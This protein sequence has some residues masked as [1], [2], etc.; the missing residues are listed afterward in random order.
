MPDARVAAKRPP[1]ARRLPQALVTLLEA[2][3]PLELG[4]SL[5]SLLRLPQTPDGDGHP[6]L[7]L[8]GFGASDASMEPL[9][10]F[11][12][13]K[14]YAVETWGLGRNRGFDRRFIELVEQKIRYL[15]HKSARR[16]SVV[17]WS[18]GGVF[19]FY[20]AHAAPE[21]VRTAISLG[22]PLRNDADRGMPFGI[23]M[24]Y[25]AISGTSAANH[26][27]RSRSRRMREP[28]PSPSTCIYSE[29]D[30]F[31]RP[32]QATLDGAPSDHENIR[33][34]G[35]HLGLAINTSVVLI[36]A[37]RLAQPE[38]KW[39]PFDLSALPERLRGDVT[40][41]GPLAVPPPDAAPSRGT[42]RSSR[43]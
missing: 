34:T 3:M 39:R 18:L 16:V 30:A 5:L 13:R 36:I 2:R 4:A 20:A 42:P 24:A 12:A 6:V 27:A 7:L 40:P 14:N 15:H 22:S 17:G 21:C 31:V 9:R 25:R 8:P 10:L 29:I 28:P 26:A 38:G 32:E 37:D 33:V 23:R 19:A 43:G 1:P 41:I 11:L 35:S